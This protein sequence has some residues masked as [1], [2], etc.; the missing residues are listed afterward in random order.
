MAREENEK[1]IRRAK[2]NYWDGQSIAGA[3]MVVAEG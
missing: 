1:R 3:V 2:M